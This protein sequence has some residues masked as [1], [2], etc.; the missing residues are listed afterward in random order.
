MHTNK[1][2]IIGGSF[3]III[4]MRNQT[5]ILNLEN[6]LAFEW[7]VEGKIVEAFITRINNL[8]DQIEAIR[9]V[10]LSNKLVWR[11][12]HVLHP[13]YSGMVTTLTT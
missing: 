2:Q 5:T 12:I 13:K 10:K 4:K 8:L 11:C 6:H 3:K 1:Q 9:M 7:L